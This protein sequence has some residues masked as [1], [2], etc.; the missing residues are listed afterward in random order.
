MLRF[1]VALGT[2][3]T[4]AGVTSAL[5]VPA[6]V[7][8]VVALHGPNAHPAAVIPASYTTMTPTIACAM[9]Y[10]PIPPDLHRDFAGSID[11]G[12]PSFDVTF[13]IERADLVDHVIVRFATDWGGPLA[14]HRVHLEDGAH[15]VLRDEEGKTLALTGAPTS[16]K[17]VARLTGAALLG[18]EGVRATVD[19]H[20]AE[21]M[22]WSRAPVEWT[23]VADVPPMGGEARVPLDVE[24]AVP[25]DVKVWLREGPLTNADVR[26]LDEL[27]NSV[28]EQRVQGIAPAGGIVAGWPLDPRENARSS[29]S[30]RDAGA[31][32]P[33]QF[34]VALT[35]TLMPPESRVG[36][37]SSMSYAPQAVEMA[38]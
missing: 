19:V 32:A 37:A 28:H 9:T 16:G 1:L 7:P 24:R 6:P 29:L 25:S 30:I 14:T 4:S 35:A 22:Q 17:F 3:L 21:R 2:L 31:S 18:V 13:P 20:Y 36:C 34:V 12:A 33:S 27:G 15:R 38:R 10:R 8:T 26:L 11:A 23:F 5:L